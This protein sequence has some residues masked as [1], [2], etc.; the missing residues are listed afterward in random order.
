VLNRDLEYVGLIFD[1][2]V[3]SFGWNF[4]YDDTRGRSVAVHSRAILE[5]LRKIYGM[6]SLADELTQSLVGTN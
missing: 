4:A 6:D 5:A 2:N 3:Y 1:G